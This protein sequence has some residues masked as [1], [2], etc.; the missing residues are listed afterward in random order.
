MPKNSAYPLLVTLLV[1]CF[2]AKTQAQ[3]LS[4]EK[5][6]IEG[7]YQF[8]YQWLNHNDSK[9]DIAFTLRQA[10]LFDRFRYFKSYHSEYAQ[11]TIIRRI[12]Q[13][14]QQNPIEGVQIAYGKADK[15]SV[16]AYGQDKKKVADAYE[17]ITLIQQ[18]IT[19]A[20]LK[21]IY[22]QE[23][24]SHQQVTA[25]KVD[26]ARIANDSVHDLKPLKPIILDVV[27]IQNP[28]EVTNFVVSFVQ[29]I[30]YNKLQ[31]R[32]TSSGAGFNPPLKLLW[33]NQGDCDSKMTLTAAL[34]RALMPRIE[35][36]FIYIEEHAF[37]GINIPAKPEEMTIRHDN[38][39]YL[40]ADPTGP[41]LLPVGIVGPESELAIVQ[42]QYSIQRF[43]ELLTPKPN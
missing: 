23:F 32:L 25:I 27:S 38:I 36:V 43:H 11:K 24:T 16:Q 5:L 17:Q 15:F 31:S 39:T 10:G 4:Y 3:Q 35:M 37:I 9:E 42:G 41:A 34:L 18:K 19:Q 29:S 40:L 2:I 28:R 13:Q 22:Y 14:M 8:E 1:T 6:A 12:K 26:H 21:E 7:G 30:P 20:Y 33:E